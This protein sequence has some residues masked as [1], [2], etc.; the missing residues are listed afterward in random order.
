M[1]NSVMPTYKMTY[2]KPEEQLVIINFSCHPSEAQ[3]T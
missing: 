1:D 3:R 2:K